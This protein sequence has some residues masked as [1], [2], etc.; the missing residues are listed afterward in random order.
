MQ[1]GLDALGF[2]NSVSSR[3]PYWQ[4]LGRSALLLVRSTLS[5]RTLLASESYPFLLHGTAYCRLFQALAGIPHQ[6]C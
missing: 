4:N 6:Y 5:E 1:A 2:A 3:L